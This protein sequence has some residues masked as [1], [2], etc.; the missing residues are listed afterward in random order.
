[1]MGIGFWVRS[2]Q[3]ISLWKKAKR[4]FKL[5]GEEGL[6]LINAV[7]HPAGARIVLDILKKLALIDKE[8]DEKER[9][10]IQQFADAWN[11]DVDFDEALAETAEASSSQLYVQLRDR[12]DDYLAI[13]PDKTQASHLLDLLNSLVSADS[14]VSREETF[15]LDE[16]RGMIEAYLG[17]SEAKPE[18]GVILVPQNQEKVAAIQVLLPDV[19]PRN[20]WGGEVY[21]AGIFHSRP[22]AEMISKKYQILDLFA[23]VNELDPVLETESVSGSAA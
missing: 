22:Y 8:L 12:I 7:L 21:Y 23:T 18:Y 2:E 17:N 15:I 20:E 19:Q 13:S 3:K 11:V 5:E 4:A 6:D 10:F 14:Q 9:A 16:V 1:M